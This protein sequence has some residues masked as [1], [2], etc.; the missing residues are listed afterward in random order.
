M[1]F[2]FNRVFVYTL[3]NCPFSK[4]SLA[5]DQPEVRLQKRP[6]EQ[7]LLLE[8]MYAGTMEEQLIVSL[9]RTEIW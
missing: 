1:I 4:W 8:E 7:V 9:K 2:I 5:I 3:I 6:M